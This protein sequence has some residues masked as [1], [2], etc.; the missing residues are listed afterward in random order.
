MPD[1]SAAIADKAA[2]TVQIPATDGRVDPK[3]LRVA[4]AGVFFSG[5]GP[6]M[7]R[8][9]PVDTAATNSQASGPIAEH[10][11]GTSP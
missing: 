3:A 7:V 4:L 11:W 2:K 9:S 10:A 6:L 8:N 5:F 1:I